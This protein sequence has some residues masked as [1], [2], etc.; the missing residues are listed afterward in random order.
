MKVLFKKKMCVF[1]K[2]LM[3]TKKILDFRKK[4]FFKKYVWKESFG[5]VKVLFKK[6]LQKY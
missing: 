1:T 6:N 5:K 3:F 2:V 4:S